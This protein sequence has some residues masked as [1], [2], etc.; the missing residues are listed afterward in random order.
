[1]K[2]IGGRINTYLRSFYGE[3]LS[4][5]PLIVRNLLWVLLK[6]V[7]VKLS[8][9]LIKQRVMKVY[10]G[11]RRSRGITLCILDTGTRCSGQITTLAPFLQENQPPLPNNWIGYSVGFKDYGFNFKT[12]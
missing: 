10:E 5:K 1:M 8:L 11:T 12:F 9:C 3:S 2:R 7:K 6:D 4:D